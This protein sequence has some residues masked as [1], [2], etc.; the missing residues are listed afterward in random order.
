MVQRDTEDDNGDPYYA[1]IDDLSWENGG[2]RYDFYRIC[3]V[4]HD[5]DR[6]SRKDLMTQKRQ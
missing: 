6:I 3:G 5:S 2:S 4:R 1:I